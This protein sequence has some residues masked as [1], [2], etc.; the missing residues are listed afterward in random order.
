MAVVKAA[1]EASNHKRMLIELGV[2]ERVIVGHD[3][4]ADREAAG[5]QGQQPVAEHQGHAAA[6][7]GRVGGFPGHPSGF[8]TEGGVA[9]SIL[10]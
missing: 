1:L 2:G 3:R 10:V 5:G 9:N 7:K 4:S 8:T 6:H